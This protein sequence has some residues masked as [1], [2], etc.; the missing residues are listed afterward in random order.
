MFANGCIKNRKYTLGKLTYGKCTL[1]DIIVNI[2]KNKMVLTGDSRTITV[3]PEEPFSSVRQ[4]VG[5]FFA[6]EK[7]LKDGVERLGVTG[8]FKRKPVI[9]IRPKELVEG[10]L[11]EVEDRC[12]RELAL[13]AGAREVKI[14]L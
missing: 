3:T 7:C 2:Y 13:G 1:M 14:E 8:L 12:L 4:L 5:K 6:A 10:G 9:I 11:S